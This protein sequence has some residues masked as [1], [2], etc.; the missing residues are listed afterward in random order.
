MQTGNPS[1]RRDGHFASWGCPCG[2]RS[3]NS[4]V[5]FVDSD[6]FVGHSVSCNFTCIASEMP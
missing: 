5:D 4:T 2:C 1:R 3:A 6:Q